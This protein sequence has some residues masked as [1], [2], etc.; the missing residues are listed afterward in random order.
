M[1]ATLDGV[2]LLRQRMVTIVRDY[3]D[4]D[5]DG[6]KRLGEPIDGTAFFPGGHGVSKERSP[7]GPLPADFRACDRRAPCSRMPFEA[8]R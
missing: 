1:R 4:T 8:V 2:T 3:D 7:P 5:P 6:V